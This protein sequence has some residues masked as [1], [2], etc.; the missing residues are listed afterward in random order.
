MNNRILDIEI[1]Q[2]EGGIADKRRLFVFLSPVVYAVLI[3][4]DPGF[5]FV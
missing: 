2:I 4:I 5:Q 3:K 1:L